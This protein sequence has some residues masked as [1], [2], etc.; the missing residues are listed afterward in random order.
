MHSGMPS[1]W[2][3]RLFLPFWH[4]QYMEFS[5]TWSVSRVKAVRLYPQLSVYRYTCRFQFPFLSTIK[6]LQVI[7]QERR[8]KGRSYRNTSHFL[9]QFTIGVCFL[10]H[11]SFNTASATLYASNQGFSRSGIRS[12]N[13]S[14]INL[15]LILRSITLRYLVLL[16]FLV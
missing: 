7:L 2:Y 8:K 15:S 1:S 5:Y 14:G 4:R 13:S 3:A 6:S 9:N 11:L 10:R 16:S 12:R